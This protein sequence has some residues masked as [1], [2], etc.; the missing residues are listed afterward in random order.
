MKR[1]SRGKS[2]FFVE[3]EKN[4]RFPLASGMNSGKEAARSEPEKPF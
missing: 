4:N 1:C 3:N 2:S